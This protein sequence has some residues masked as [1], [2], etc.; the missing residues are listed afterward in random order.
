MYQ[1]RGRLTERKVKMESKKCEED[2]NDCSLRWR[3]SKLMGIT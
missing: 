2:V 3:S 1:R